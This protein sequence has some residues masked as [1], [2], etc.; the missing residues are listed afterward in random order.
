MTLDS[1]NNRD[2]YPPIKISDINPALSPL[3]GKT[4]D[5]NALD[6]LFG[7]LPIGELSVSRQELYVLG[8]TLD[9]ETLTPA[10]VYFS[11]P[12]QT[13]IDALEFDPVKVEQRIR[14]ADATA[15]ELVSTLLYEIVTLRS[16]DAAPLLRQIPAAAAEPLMDRITRL[17][18]ATQRV[19]I[20]KTRCPRI[21]RA[22]S[23]SPRAG[24]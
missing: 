8:A 10:T 20:R 4:P 18:N 12:D 19:D 9:G 2:I 15:S 13:F 21:C 1:N 3:P 22:G 14:S 5:L 23:I 6:K 16:P 17:L 11:E 24:A 7:P